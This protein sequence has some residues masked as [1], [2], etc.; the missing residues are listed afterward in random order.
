MEI[1]ELLAAVTPPAKPV[2]NGPREVIPSVEAKIGLRLPEDLIQFAEQY[3][4]GTL[5]TTLTVYNP[6]SEHY[7][8]DSGKITNLYR[9][10]KQNEGDEFIPY[11]IHPSNPGLYSFATDVNGHTLWWLTEGEPEK[12]PILLMT[13]DAAFER[14]EMSMTTFL[15]KIFRA[16]IDCLLWDRKWLRENFVGI[17]FN[18]EA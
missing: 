5:G 7:H 6:F 18:P 8:L 10:L 15:A 13:V 14:W 11:D 1:S 3:G 9:M 17:Q 2:E 16:E 4:S 12:W